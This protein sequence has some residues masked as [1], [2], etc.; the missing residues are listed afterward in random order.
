MKNGIWT[1]VGLYVALAI[2]SSIFRFVK[3]NFMTISVWVGLIAFAAIILGNYSKKKNDERLRKEKDLIKKIQRTSRS[4]FVRGYKISREVGWVNISDC[5]STQ[6]VEEKLKLKAAEIGA[7]AII[8]LHWNMRKESYVAGHGKKGNPYYK[9]RSVY[10]GEGVAAII[11]KSN[12]RT[13]RESGNSKNSTT[14]AE[15]QDGYESGWIAIDGNNVFGEVFK[16]IDDTS[17]TFAI[18]RKFFLKLSHSPY[19]AHI[20]WDGKFVKF[21]HATDASSRGEG[22]EAILKSNLGI[23]SES[24]TISKQGQRADTLLVPWA[25]AKSAVI[26][27]NDNF[28]KDYEDLLIAGKAKDLRNANRILKCNF[29]A[30]EIIVPELIAL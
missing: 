15:H 5:S 3:E 27:S 29:I 9:N 13:R 18:L 10:D 6:E 11:E 28:L 14:R 26:I 17:A 1:I 12:P 7:N 30:G 21:A 19:K 20:F 24:L 8:K 4:D 22:L 2:L 23:S 16:Q 25:H